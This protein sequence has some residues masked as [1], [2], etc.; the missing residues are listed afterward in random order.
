MADD[1]AIGLRALASAAGLVAA[2]LPIFVFLHGRLLDRSSWRIRSTIFP[3][4]L[5]ALALTILHAL[6]EPVRLSGTWSG[7]FDASLHSLLLQSDFGTTIAVRVL[8]LAIIAACLRKSGQGGER[9]A[10]IGAALVATS[11]TL[12]GHTAADP[13]RWLL[14]PL[15]FVHLIAIAFW[16]GSLWP[17]STVARFESAAVAG[18]VI[19]RFS[20]TALRVVPFILLAGLA[21]SALL[22]PGLSSL[23]TPYGLLLLTKLGG[24]SM[25]MALAGLNK[26]RLAR[27]ISLGDQSSVAAFRFSVLAEWILIFAVITVTAVMT[28]LFSPEH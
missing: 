3:T 12:M 22:L 7:V 4:A 2:G 23:G 14:A 1:F 19:G 9:F 17:L 16:F 10:V 28:G 11:F 5:V 24:F 27:G 18:A 8:G 25:L 20:R 15:L 6:V 21:M 13:Q 26:W